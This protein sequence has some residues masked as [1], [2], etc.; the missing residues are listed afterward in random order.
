MITIHETMNSL[1]EC[2]FYGSNKWLLSYLS[3]SSSL[4]VREPYK[5]ANFSY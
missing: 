5:D 2:A 1:M 4:S 3:C